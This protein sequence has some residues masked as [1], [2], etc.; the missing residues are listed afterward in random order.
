[1]GP[2]GFSASPRRVVLRQ[3]RWNNAALAGQQAPPGEA[4]VRQMPVLTVLLTTVTAALLATF[5]AGCTAALDKSE[6]F[7]R[8]RYSRLLQPFDKPA[9]IY[10]DVT[11]SADYPA[12]DP[13]ADAVRMAWLQGW[14][15]QRRLCPAG[16]EVPVRRAFDYLEDNPAG[17]Q[18]R[19]EV[20]CQDQ[21]A[22]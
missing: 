9:T 6:D 17:Y 14:L 3:R 4:P 11:F 19:W 13:A 12:D 18:Q 7:D 21:G 16:F 15:T 20:R 1:M 8:H 5:L 2:D 22:R 10:F